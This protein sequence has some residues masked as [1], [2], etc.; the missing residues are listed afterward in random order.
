[1]YARWEGTVPAIELRELDADNWQTCVELEL[2]DD[3]R[4]IV[5]SNAFSIAESK[6]HLWMLPLAIYAGDEM[7]GFVMYSDERDPRL[8]RYWVHRLMIDRRHQHRGYGRAAMQ[9]VIQRIAAKPDGDEVWIGY[10]RDNDVARRL[11]A[12]LGFEE[13]GDAPWGDTDV[14]ARLTLDQRG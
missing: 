2:T 10:H 14:I 13:Q 12:S 9:D 11:Y 3:Q 5:D 4:H 1:M 7:V 6:F 8:P